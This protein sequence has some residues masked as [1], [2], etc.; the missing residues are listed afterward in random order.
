MH[1]SNQS[2]YTK[3]YLLQHIIVSHGRSDIFDARLECICQLAVR[4]L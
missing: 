3:A 1:G 4:C 2:I